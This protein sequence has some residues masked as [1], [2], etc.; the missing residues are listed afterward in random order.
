MN[1][2]REMAANTVYRCTKEGAYSNLVISVILAQKELGEKDRGLYA[3]LVYTT[4]ERLLTIDYIISL[5]SNREMYRIDET[6][7]NNLRIGVCQLFYMDKIPESAIV[8]EAVKLTPEDAKPFVNAVLRN[9]CRNKQSLAEKAESSGDSIKYSIS[10]DI[11]TLIDTQYHDQYDEILQ[12]TRRRLP[13]VLRVNTLRITYNGLKRR[14]KGSRVSDIVPDT[15][16][17]ITENIAQT[18]S[19]R[20]NFYYIQGEPS[21]YAVKLLDPQPYDIVVDIAACPGGKTMGAAIQ[22][23]NKGRIIALDLH[24]NKIQLIEKTARRLGVKIVET[25]VHDGR[26][27]KNNLIGIADRVICDVPCSALGVINAKPE[28]RYKK[29]V[30]ISRLP[31]VQYNLLENASKYLK[32]GGTIV[33]STCTINKDENEGVIDRYMRE[34]DDLYITEKRTFMT[35]TDNTEGFFVCRMEKKFDI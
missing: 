22:M 11:L 14:M 15:G 2:P 5:N 19:D 31:L 8:D 32:P 26:T 9:I 27:T 7:K 16:L 33:Y 4:L 23:N 3:A 6:V 10:P 25:C 20:S 18:A 12:A 21:Q 13:L 17:I 29:A 1:N 30:N 34:H 24:D 35:Y 28:V